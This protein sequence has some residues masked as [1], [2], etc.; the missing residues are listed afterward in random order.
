MAKTKTNEQTKFEKVSSE[1]KR[2]AVKT[3]KE[4]RKQHKKTGKEKSSTEII[5]HFRE[6]L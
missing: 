1:K 6:K 5:R 2:Q 4:I 3:M